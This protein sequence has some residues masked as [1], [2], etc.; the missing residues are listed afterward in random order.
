MSEHSPDRRVTSRRRLLRGAAGLSVGLP[1]LDAFARP[2]GAS[3]ATPAKPVFAAI[4]VEMNGV[5]QGDSS[6]QNEPE[7]FWPSSLGALTQTSMDAD[8]GRA[9]SVLSAYASK[10]LMVRN[11]R[12]PFGAAGCAHS[13]SGNQLL[14]A[15]KYGPAGAKSLAFGESVDNY[16]GRMVGREPLNLYAGSKG[17]YID[18]HISFRG[19]SDV[20]VGEGDPWVAYQKIVGMNNGNAAAAAAIASG[21]KSVNDFLREELTG[22]RGRSDLSMDDRR[23][24]D[25]HFQA[26]RDIEVKVTTN[27]PDS[28]TADMKTVDGKQRTDA[29]RLKVVELQYDIMAFALASGYTQIVVLQSGDGT[30]GMQYVIDGVTLPR[31]H[32]LSHRATSDSTIGDSPMKGQMEIWHHQIDIIRLNL[33]KHLLDNMAMYTTPEGS[34][35]DVGFAMWTNTVATGYHRQTNLPF[36]IA[37]DARGYF[38]TG[39]HVTANGGPI[40]DAAKDCVTNNQL[41]NTL[42]GAFG[43]QKPGG[44]PVDDFG[45][46]SLPKGVLTGLTS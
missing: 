18:D 31:F 17:G 33:F 3:G 44:G 20:R 25:L 29:A 12:L 4:V 35:L 23:R 43:V 13:S 41:L 1:L 8:S 19:P 46:A 24:L 45:D 40:S 34:L 16:I 26:I 37:G 14:T 7:R 30:D 36:L 6:G 10:L 11:I 42:I 28:V 9:T 32:P 27:L 15:A 2:R 39:Q 5:Q 38:K 22:L 21:R